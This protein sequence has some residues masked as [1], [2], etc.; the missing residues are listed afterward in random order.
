MSIYH[1]IGSSGDSDKPKNNKAHVAQFCGIC[2]EA[3][4]QGRDNFGIAH[5]AAC[6]DTGKTAQADY[7]KNHFMSKKANTLSPEMSTLL[8]KL[9]SQKESKSLLEGT[10]TSRASNQLNGIRSKAE[11]K[12]KQLG[13]VASYETIRSQVMEYLPAIVAELG[14]ADKIDIELVADMIVPS[15]IHTAIQDSQIAKSAIRS[16]VMDELSRFH[17]TG[18]MLQSEAKFQPK[19]KISQRIAEASSMYEG[20]TRT[21]G[22]G[23]SRQID[24]T[25]NPMMMGGAPAPMAP[26]MPPV[27]PMTPLMDGSQPPVGA[28]IGEGALPDAPMQETPNQTGEVAGFVVRTEDVQPHS[29]DPLGQA[30]PDASGGITP[31]GDP[32]MGAAVPQS[33]PMDGGMMRVQQS[34]APKVRIVKAQLE[35]IKPSNMSLFSLAGRIAKNVP[36]QAIKLDASAKLTLASA[37]VANYITAAYTDGTTKTWNFYKTDKGGIFSSAGT[38]FYAEEA[39][40]F[41]SFL[42][43]DPMFSKFAFLPEELQTMDQ[44]SPNDLSGALPQEALPPQPNPQAFEG[45]SPTLNEIEPTVL[46]PAG[47]NAGGLMNDQDAI[48]H[49]QDAQTG[50]DATFGI[51]TLADVAADALPMMEEQHPNATPDQHMNMALAT[52]IDYLSF[53]KTAAG[54]FQHDPNR[55]NYE[56]YVNRIKTRFPGEYRQFINHG[57]SNRDQK[58]SLPD[59]LENLHGGNSGQQQEYDPMAMAKEL[60]PYGPDATSEYKQDAQSR[61]TVDAERAERTTQENQQE[62]GGVGYEDPAKRLLPTMVPQVTPSGVKVDVPLDKVRNQNVEQNLSSTFVHPKDL[63]PITPI[64]KDLSDKDPLGG[65]WEHNEGPAPSLRYKNKPVNASLE[66]IEVAGSM[67]ENEFYEIGLPALV[68]AGYT[69]DEIISAIAEDTLVFSDYSAVM[70]VSHPGT[71]DED[72]KHGLHHATTEDVLAEG[73]EMMDAK[74]ETSMNAVAAL[75]CG[76]CGAENINDSHAC[77]ANAK[78]PKPKAPDAE[79]AFLGKKLK[80]DDHGD[81]D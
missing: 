40:H 71:A 22:T 68:A 26:V 76:D 19:S 3:F 55:E 29:M 36:V 47:E 32:G 69:D 37:P 10:T 2:Q 58:T 45:G 23:Y 9:S 80:N 8:D 34:A 38:E 64:H 78:T 54:A 65:G 53:V 81:F 31:M 67:S 7:W 11:I 12:A 1:F 14:L 27:T 59:F 77:P 49:N 44:S 62:I 52:A 43:T 72:A 16:I 51:D 25:A 24:R 66:I 60:H 28:A 35:A 6:I 61:A 4:E 46:H 56:Q 70:D 20:I 42:T 48:F 30:M 41:A 63:P 74:V 17:D 39:T 13:M 50:G 5:C 18:A 75:G 79:K 73:R 21:N 33:A 57:I 15:K